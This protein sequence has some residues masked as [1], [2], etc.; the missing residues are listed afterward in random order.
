MDASVTFRFPAL[1]RAGERENGISVTPAQPAGTLSIPS[2][3]ILLAGICDGD[4]EALACLFHRYA[5]MVRGVAYRV[6]QDPSEA[7]DL[8]QDIFLL[9]HRDCK[10][11]DSSR[12]P[13]Q[14]WILQMAYRRAIS[15]RRH[16][17][18][19]HFY[20]RVNL[21]DAA[22]QIPDPRAMDTDLEDSFDGIFGNGSLKKTFDALSENQRQTL[23]L[24]FMEG[25]TLDEIAQK[26]GESPGNVKNHYFRG[27]DKLRKL[28]FVTKLP[29]G[30][31]V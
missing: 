4:K 6:L 17:T 26:L 11:F 27:L 29:G 24:F 31:P 18:V 10:K 25:Y 3:E 16:L 7:D 12:G 2:D 23:S 19:R 30:R 1:A 13:A 20:N 21:D 9:V 22:T 15:R 8:V 28:L 5:R 14:F